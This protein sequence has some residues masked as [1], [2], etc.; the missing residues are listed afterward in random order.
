MSSNCFKTI[1]F[2]L[3]CH[4]SCLLICKNIS[5]AYL[6]GKNMLMNVF[7]T[8]IYFICFIS[9]RLI[10]VLKIRNKY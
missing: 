7:N 9:I 4:M 1:I 3:L 5:N 10:L 6:K 8:N 2:C